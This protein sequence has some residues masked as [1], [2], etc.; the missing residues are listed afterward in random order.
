MIPGP[1][2]ALQ[3]AELPERRV[4]RGGPWCRRV[5]VLQ[6][7]LPSPRLSKTL[8]GSRFESS[9]SSAFPSTFSSSPSLSSLGS[10]AR[11]CGAV[12]PPLSE[13]PG[14][15]PQALA[16]TT[17]P[18]SVITD[19]TIIRISLAYG[20]RWLHHPL[21]FIVVASEVVEA[22]G[23]AVAESTRPT[24]SAEASI[25]ALIIRRLV[26]VPSLSLHIAQRALQHYGLAARGD[27]ILA[28][29]GADGRIGLGSWPGGGRLGATTNVAD[30]ISLL[31]VLALSFITVTVIAGW[32][33]SDAGVHR[34]MGAAAARRLRGAPLLAVGRLRA[35]HLRR[36]SSAFG[37]SSMDGSA[38][39]GPLATARLAIQDHQA[40]LALMAVATANGRS[41]AVRGSGG[42][43]RRALTM[44]SW[45]WRT[46]WGM[47]ATSRRSSL[48]LPILATLPL[49]RA[50]RGTLRAHPLSSSCCKSIIFRQRALPRPRHGR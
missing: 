27:P 35:S 11:G 18:M 29:A 36:S 50:P 34:R 16:V 39:R 2:C 32:T 46:P 1:L 17:I 23:A 24:L 48:S 45:I 25:L 4:A 9:P 30:A 14:G 47:T 13:S 44:H 37:S 28:A 33:L 38:L 31:M 49:G 41:T 12:Q 15:Q 42:P 20:A 6:Q 43:I 8:R 40:T 21:L 22:V 26:L 19:V 5:E 7:V 3:R 10:A